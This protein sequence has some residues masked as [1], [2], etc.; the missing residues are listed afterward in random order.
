MRSLEVYAVAY[1]QL[2]GKLACKSD[3]FRSTVIMTNLI[4]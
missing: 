3:L 4:V 1:N 2:K